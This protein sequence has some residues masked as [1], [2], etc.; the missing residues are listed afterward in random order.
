[1]NNIANKKEVLFSSLV[2]YSSCF[3]LKLRMRMGIHVDHDLVS[4]RVSTVFTM[5][6]DRG[7][8]TTPLTPTIDYC[9]A[10]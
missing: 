6:C 1:M 8:M 9:L 2:V 10:Y 7:L 5:S 3:G 4:T